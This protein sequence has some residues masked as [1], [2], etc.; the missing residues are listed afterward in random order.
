MNREEVH[1]DVV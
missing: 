1:C